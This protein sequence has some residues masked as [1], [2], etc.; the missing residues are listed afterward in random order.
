MMHDWVMCIISCFVIV[1]SC[2]IKLCMYDAF[3]WCVSLVAWVLWKCMCFSVHDAYFFYGSVNYIMA[4]M[5]CIEC[6]SLQ[7]YFKLVLLLVLYVL[8]GM[9]WICLCIALY[10]F[11]LCVCGMTWLETR[12]FA[13]YIKLCSNALSST[14]ALCCVMDC[15]ILTI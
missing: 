8:I 5:C 11:A 3:D 10:S 6:L 7:Y 13:G 1:L 9:L 14:H 2:G 12:Y 4:T 15:W